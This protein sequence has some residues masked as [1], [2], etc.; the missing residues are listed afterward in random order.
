[1]AGRLRA[2]SVRINGAAADLSAPFGGYKR[3]GNG[4]ELG[5]HGLS[6]FLEVKAI[7]R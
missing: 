7:A 4:R 1:V 6:E 3:S 2:G 5:I